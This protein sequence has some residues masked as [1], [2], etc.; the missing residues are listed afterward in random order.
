MCGLPGTGVEDIA[1][2]CKALAC[3]RELGDEETYAALRKWAE[4]H[5]QPIYDPHRGEFYCMFGLGEAYPR[6]QHN[7]WIMP[8]YVSN[9][10]RAWHRLFNQPNLKKFQEPTLTDVDF[11][12]VRVRQAYYD[13]TLRTLNVALCTVDATA[14]GQET[15][16]QITNLAPSARYRVLMDGQ[17]CDGWQLREGKIQVR[18]TVG[19]H[20]FIIQQHAV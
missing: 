14:L 13:P 7:D 12:L 20:S 18:T 3:A 8:G 6:G 1:S 19:T 4:A 5:Y 15:T 17:E 2:T 9:G 10:P 11:P 16:F